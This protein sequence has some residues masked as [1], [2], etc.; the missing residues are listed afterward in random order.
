[1]TQGKSLEK[2]ETNI[3]EPAQEAFGKRNF[4]TKQTTKQK[5]LNKKTTNLG[6]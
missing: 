3:T 5:C 6:A 1:M 4:N 2:I